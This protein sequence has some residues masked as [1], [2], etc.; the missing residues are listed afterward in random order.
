MPA[1]VCPPLFPS[2]TGNH[3]WTMQHS[4]KVLMC[5]FRQAFHPPPKPFQG[6]IPGSRIHATEGCGLNLYAGF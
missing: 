1:E 4:L 6:F 2:T 5:V 3:Q